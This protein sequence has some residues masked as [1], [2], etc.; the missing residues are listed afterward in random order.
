MN[1][2]FVSWI[3]SHLRRHQPGLNSGEAPGA[4]QSELRDRAGRQEQSHG[5]GRW[6]WL[7]QVGQD[8]RYA[9]RQ[10]A[11]SPGFTV[12]VIITLALGIG[13]SSAIFT[14]VNSVLLRPVPY[15]E[16]GRLMVLQEMNLTR[17]PVFASVPANYRAWARQSDV[18]ESTYAVQGSVMNLVGEGEP[19]R[20]STARVTGQCF[21]T[22]RIQPLLGR[23]FGPAED[24]AGKSNVVVLTHPF[25]QRQFGGRPD[26]IGHTLRLNDQPYTVIGVMPVDFERGELYEMYTP[27]A[28]PEQV[29]QN[30]SAQLLSFAFGRLK[31]GVTLAQAR[32]QLDAIAA[33]LALEYP[34]TN[35]DVGVSVTPLLDFHVAA[36]RPAFYTILAAAGVLLLIACLNIANLLLVRTS[37]R[38]RE[39]A[40]RSALGASRR[41]IVGQL[42]GESLLLALLGGALGLLVAKWSLS[43][44]LVLVQGSL[45]RANEITLDGSV[46]A[47]TF[48]LTLLTGVAFGL[49]PGW[50]G[51]RVNVIGSLKA[52][53]R[54]MS[55]GQGTR[56]F[57]HGLI[58]AEIAL[59]LVLLTGTGLLARSFVRLS[60]VSP[61]FQS[62]GALMLWIM[63]SQ[64]GSPGKLLAFSDAVTE[65][66]RAL[67]GV[68]AVG[69]APAIPFVF[70]PFRRAIEVEGRNLPLAQQPVYIWNA[71]SAD[72]F[73]AMGIPLR[74]G[75]VFTAQDRAGSQRVAVVSQTFADQCYPGENPLGQRI[76]V[77]GAPRE[78]R[79]IVGVVGDVRPNSLTADI[80]PQVYDA[81]AQSPTMT[82]SF[83]VRASG[84]LGALPA[85]VRRELYAVDAAQ[86]VLRLSPLN[87]FVAVQKAQQ[88]F[89]LAL[90]G[91]FSG[92]ALIL[93]S[94][95]IYGTMAFTVA[96][97][98]G[99]FG[100]RLALGARA[101]DLRGL[102][103]GWG[104]RL[105]VP[106][107]ALG[108]GAA[109]ATAHLV[110]S[111]L[112]N[113]PAHDPVV[114]AG[115]ATLLGLVGLLA[116][117][118]PARRASKVDLIE[119]LKA[120]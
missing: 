31:P 77:G 107:I 27:A 28:F 120:E 56:V 48:G 19:V 10:L 36:V 110:Q 52:S 58:V 68:T 81:F 37:A 12:V 24:V 72:Y 90:V 60:R 39:I 108:A 49:A 76:S 67:P 22:L 69:V 47:F 106:G 63:R 21:E 3:K 91:V 112:Y 29:W 6:M 85:A 23:V 96:Q 109:Y 98:T 100:V 55:T 84:D 17:A 66:L 97:R 104:V 116:C 25:W 82:M 14:V 111:L 117:W 74:Q 86:A 5:A 93:A 18:F 2:R 65:R 44:M 45:P 41:R 13:A 1:N 119:S 92:V 50:F 61:G 30:R 54:S 71:A 11:R 99:E 70:G 80:I 101:G 35:R 46:V 73:Q 64:Y 102:V 59:A 43:V 114:F 26:I 115:I 113:T 40:V 95:G 51:T 103:L 83:V 94:V 33:R 75:R 79:E 42:L 105:I 38:Q 15:P 118:L 87:D 89:A 4:A 20:V 53:S 57:R 8:L 16:S 7:D 88:R 32:T 62:D 34:A 78:W 9:L